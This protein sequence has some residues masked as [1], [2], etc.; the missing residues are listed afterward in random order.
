MCPAS[1]PWTVHLIGFG[2]CVLHRFIVFDSVV[3]RR[4]GVRILASLAL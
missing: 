1:V 2:W 4:L 3:M